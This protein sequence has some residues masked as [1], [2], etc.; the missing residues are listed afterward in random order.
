MSHN[1]TVRVEK[2]VAIMCSHVTHAC[3]SVIKLYTEW[4]R[5]ARE[6]VCDTKSHTYSTWQ[7][8]NITASSPLHHREPPGSSLTVDSWLHLATRL[9]RVFWTANSIWR[10]RQQYQQQAKQ[11]HRTDGMPCDLCFHH[12]GRKRYLLII[13][14][15]GGVGKFPPG[16]LALRQAR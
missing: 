8:K 1:Q 5:C 10:Q 14:G 2:S 12:Y 3:V 16:L 15:G 4:H 13:S 6:S 7:N 11:H 9:S